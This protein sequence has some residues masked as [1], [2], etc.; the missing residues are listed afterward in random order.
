MSSR[1]ALHWKRLAA[2]A[3]AVAVLL[4]VFAA[5]LQPDMAFALAS[6]AWSCL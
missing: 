5:Y 4:A 3:A 2:W 6:W 1:N